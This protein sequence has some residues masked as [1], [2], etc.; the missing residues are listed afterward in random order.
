MAAKQIFTT[1]FDLER[2][3]S[4]IAEISAHGTRE[5]RAYAARLEE[6][7]GRAVVLDPK[8]VSHDVITMNSRF[9]IRDLNF[10]DEA[11]YTVVFPQEADLFEDK[12]SVLAPLGTAMLGHRVGD[13]IEWHAPRGK[14]NW[15]V[16]EIAYQPEAAGHYH[17]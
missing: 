7:L 10:Q 3:R 6:K 1:G 2:L 17:L 9:R 13:M 14:C 15:R 16:E 12:L 4:L 8:T 5:E 11:S